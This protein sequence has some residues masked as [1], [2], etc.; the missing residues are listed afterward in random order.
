MKYNVQD[1]NT[2]K[3]LDIVVCTTPI[4][5]TPT[6]YPPFGS[7]A[8]IQALRAAGW[9]P[10]FYDIDGLR[11]SFAEVETFFAER[12][13]D[14]LG[15]SAVVSTA[16]TYTKQLARMVR[17]VSPRTRIVL[18]GNLA[19]SAEIMHRLAGIDYCVSGEGEVVVVNLMSYLQDRAERRGLSGDDHDALSRVRGLSY[20]R[21]D[22]QMTFTGFE[23]RLPPAEIADPDYTILET[24]SRIGNFITDPM[25][26]PAFAWDPRAHEPKRKGKM[27]G[28]VVSTKGCVARCTFCHRWEKG[29]RAFDAEKV[30]GMI[31]YLMERYNVGFI[32]FGDEN[33]GSDRAE[34][35]ALIEAVKPLDILYSIAGVRCRTVDPELLRRLKESGCVS[36]YYGME[37]GSQRILDV[38]EKN[39]T[40]Q[41]N[42]NAAKWTVEAGL[43]T[44]YQLVV[45]MPGENDETISESIETFKKCTEL[46]PE[47][48]IKR[49]SVNFIQALPGTP[50]YEY[51]RLKGLIGRSLAEEEKYLEL[52]SDIDAADDTKFLNFTDC[53]YLTVQ[54]WRRRLILECIAHYR[55]VRGL[56]APSLSDIYEHVVL[57]RLDP[58]RYEA[59][60]LEAEKKEGG[61]SYTK[62]GY[63][64]LQ[65]SLYYDIIAAYLYPVRTPV[66]WLWLLAR[67]YQRLGPASFARRVRETLRHRIFGSGYDSYNDYRSL[68]KVV[69]GGAPK[70]AGDT[71]LA[72]APFRAG[73]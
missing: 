23:T 72:M 43:Y 29:Y 10:Y 30:V 19:A 60:R 36:V 24:R 22:G 64:N 32:Q 67:E 44:I 49:L 73:R 14:V 16:Y 18:G 62:G 45:G 56:P 34:V 47:N 9:D 41:H 17:R 46:L 8:V 40:L 42:L 70:P 69:D 39:T 4:R 68:R 35:S 53:D 50:V 52:I 28:T 26:N 7:M 71:E 21:P 48:P 31:K 37:T 27:M 6:D 54:S 20:L 2:A 38:M 12:Q 51:A 13:P 57:Q 55:R 61:L 3:S 59:L 11:P 65:R 66:L 15:I 25:T 5:P 1:L 63:F 33:F 58:A